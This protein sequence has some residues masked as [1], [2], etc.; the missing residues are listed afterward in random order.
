MISKGVKDLTFLAS[1]PYPMQFRCQPFF[2]PAKRQM[3]FNIDPKAVVKT[4]FVL[5]NTSTLTARQTVEAHALRTG[6]A[7]TLDEDTR[8][9][10]INFLHALNRGFD[11]RILRPA[12]MPFQPQ[13]RLGAPEFDYA[14]REGTQGS[15]RAAYGKHPVLLVL[16]R[17]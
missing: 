7:Q 16:S 8:W 5:P 13:P 12:S 9:D 15:L 1:V 6:F 14:T 3:N 4:G 10:V 11:A 17:V 2:Q